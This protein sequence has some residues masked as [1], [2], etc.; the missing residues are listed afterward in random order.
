MT[1]KI[2]NVEL[3]NICNAKSFAFKLNKITLLQYNKVYGYDLL[4][5]HGASLDCFFVV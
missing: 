5:L 4:F 1:Q 2:C 3:K